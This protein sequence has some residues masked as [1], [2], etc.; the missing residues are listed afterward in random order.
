MSL[1]VRRNNFDE[2]DQLTNYEQVRFGEDFY[3]PLQIE[4]TKIRELESYE[5]AYDSDELKALA[6]E[7][8]E[9]Y[10]R[11]LEEKNFEIKGKNVKINAG[12]TEISVKG[13][14]EAL[15]KAEKTQTTEIR[16]LKKEEGQEENGI[17]T[18]NNGNSS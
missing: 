4:I 6:E 18:G 17:D 5:R 10:C 8:L 9:L 11:S 3:L 13:S 7:H 14:L 2:W 15:E 1:N 16:T 12:K